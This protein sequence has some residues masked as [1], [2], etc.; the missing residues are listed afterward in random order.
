MGQIGLFFT[1]IS[2]KKPTYDCQKIKPNDF[3]HANRWFGGDPSTHGDQPVMFATYYYE[4]FK[5]LGV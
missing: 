2:K 5:S 1:L 4:P 3:A